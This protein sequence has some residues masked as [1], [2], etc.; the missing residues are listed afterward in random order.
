M[1]TTTTAAI[2]PTTSSSTATPPRKEPRSSLTRTLKEKAEFDVFL[3]ST[4]GNKIQVIK[5]VR[6]L[7]GL[8]PRDAKRL[9]NEAP[10]MIA[11]G[12]SKEEAGEMK[13]QLE[14]AGAIVVLYPRYGL[15]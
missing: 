8:G 6:R 5:T 12:V 13:E 3:W 15:T 2:V 4:A 7:T 9:V 1:T 14:Q 11:E 10:T